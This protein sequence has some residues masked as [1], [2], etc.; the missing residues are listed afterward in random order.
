MSMPAPPSTPIGVVLSRIFWM[1]FGPLMLVLL[2]YRTAERGAGWVTPTDIAYCVVLIS[3]PLA[4]WRE[5]LG[6]DPRTSTGEPA[7]LG[8]FRKYAVVTI[9]VGVA[10]WMVT[11]LFAGTVA[12]IESTF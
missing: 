6:G 8:H 10:A 12:P 1:L 5:F 3:L 11:K 9:L 7:D 2:L 4:R